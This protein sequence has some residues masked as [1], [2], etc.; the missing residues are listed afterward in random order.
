MHT[1]EEIIAE[2]EQFAP[3]SLQESWDNSGLQI[4]HTAPVVSGVL[5]TL[6]LT[7]EILEEALALR[8]NLI[9]SHHPLIFRPVRK[10]GFSNA[11]ERIIRKAIQHDIAIY[12]A[13]TN[14]DAVWGGVNT[15]L[16]KKLELQN[17]SILEPKLQYL[18]N[19]V[20]LRREQEPF[21]LS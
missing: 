19:V 7:E 3:L 16:A 12:S 5:I 8:C 4:G 6:D 17:I 14:L 13:H 2:I 9:L 11:T 21:N 20:F 15:E 10:L 18:Y 1:L